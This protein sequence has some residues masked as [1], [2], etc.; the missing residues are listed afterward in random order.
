M[1]ITPVPDSGDW[2]PRSV[3]LVCDRCGRSFT[4]GVLEN[5]AG[6]VV[7]TVGFY[8]REHGWGEFMAAGENT[9]CDRCL[10]P[11]RLRRVR[12]PRTRLGRR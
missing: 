1:H 4:G 6:E 12:Y 3:T 2:G 8:A 11:G 5:G 10:P 9:L 7:G